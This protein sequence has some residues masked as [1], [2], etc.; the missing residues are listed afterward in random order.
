MPRNGL[1]VA[2][3]HEAAHGVCAASLGVPVVR[4][5]V[6]ANGGGECIRGFTTPELSAAISCAGDL[7]DREF[8]T[9]EY[10]DGSCADLSRQLQMVGVHGIWRARREAREILTARRTQVLDL[11]ARLYRQRQLVF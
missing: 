9:E 7:W 11:G 4:L 10:R 5:A 1:L 6:F 8:S 3:E 2:A